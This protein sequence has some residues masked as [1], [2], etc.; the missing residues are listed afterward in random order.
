LAQLP[1]AM[2]AGAGSSGADI[3]K[4]AA[5]EGFVAELR[6]RALAPTAEATP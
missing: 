6:S 5:A 1:P 3:T 4:L 2:Q